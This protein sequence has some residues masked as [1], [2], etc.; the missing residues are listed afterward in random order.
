[1]RVTCQSTLEGKGICN[2]VA[3]TIG[4]LSGKKKM[5]L[6]LSHIHKMNF[7]SKCERQNFKTSTGNIGDYLYD[8][9]GV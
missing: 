5:N 4:Y 3:E 2:S 1:M 9:S 8:L 7:R 6:N